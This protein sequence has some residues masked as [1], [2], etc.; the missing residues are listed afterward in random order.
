MGPSSR[1]WHRPPV[2][3]AP[4]GAGSVEAQLPRRG[5]GRWRG[6]GPGGLGL[7]GRDPRGVRWAVL[8]AGPVMGERGTSPQV[9]GR[10]S[11]PGSRV[12]L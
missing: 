6:R 4:V 5:R 7:R 2:G 3:T 12:R 11:A 1:P 8:G 9:E 10:G